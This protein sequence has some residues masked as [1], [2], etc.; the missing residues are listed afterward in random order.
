MREIATTVEAANRV[1]ERRFFTVTACV[2]G[3]AFLPS[4]TTARD[5]GRRLERETSPCLLEHLQDEIEWHPWGESAMERAR[6]KKRLV[7]ISIGRF[8]SQSSRRLESEFFESSGLADELNRRFVNVKVDYD[9]RPDIAATAFAVA[10]LSREAP[11]T[12]PP[13]P[14]VLV[15]LPDGRPV[16]GAPL[17]HETRTRLLHFAR[18]HQ[19]DAERWAT[20]SRAA[21]IASAS[22][23][24]LAPDPGQREVDATFV[25][26]IMKR[27]VNDARRPLADE[28]FRPAH[29]VLR[30]LL[31]DRLRSDNAAW[32]ITRD[33]L[34]LIER[35]GLHDQI[36]GGFHHET[37]D[38]DGR[39]PRFE[40]RLADNALLAWALSQ[41][42]RR[43]SDP[44]LSQAALGILD[45]A[46]REMLDSEDAFMAALDA[47]TDGVE[48]GFY[49][50]S[51]DEIV[52]A[53]GKTPS[54]RLFASFELGPRGVLYRQ[55]GSTDESKLL[56]VL[57]E[58]RDL[59]RRPSMD[60]RVFAGAN[61]LMIS[62]LAVSSRAFDRTADRDLA[63][64][65]AVSI[66]KRLGQPASLRRSVQG[67]TAQGSAFLTDYAALAL[68]FIDLHEATGESRWREAA[69]DFV[70]EAI[71]R[72]LDP[73]GGFFETDVAH[74][75][76]IARLKSIEDGEGL[77][78]NGAMALALHRLARFTGEGRYDDLAIRTVSAFREEIEARPAKLATL[79]A[80]AAELIETSSSS[81]P[82]VES[83]PSRT[84]RD[85]V[86][87]DVVL[88]KTQARRGEKLEARVGLALTEHWFVVGAHTK[89][90]SL[91]SLSVAVIAPEL[92]VGA[93]E[94][95]PET[96]ISPDVDEEPL[97]VH[98]GQFAIVTPLRVNNSA[99]LGERRVRIRV[100]Y[101]LCDRRECRPPESVVLE[102]PLVIMP[103]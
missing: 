43:A 21:E 101:Q 79:V 98:A 24:V 97:V 25:A 83:R 9:E 84:T 12:I 94:Y 42:H 89:S 81:T 88:T 57:R 39:L 77:S 26:S 1:R 41:S 87:I 73:N 61:G 66:L 19:D 3:L 30:V 80:A 52:E 45:W 63:R 7:L 60:T 34:R 23:D 91:A 74:E 93:P 38:E 50:W 49:L 68:G 11:V 67:E 64:R 2:V 85:P 44:L 99:S 53:L 17:T 95:P 62:A 31:G 48:G 96:T 55:D 15:L 33:L 10:R 75:P 27:V 92:V 40:K 36:G 72:F 56:S 18:D 103:K 69:Q 29:G 100:R 22:A 51:K 76:V 59:R 86:T 102:A 13:V 35:S 8:G 46:R 54:E 71:R 20:S 90:R 70:E 16:F 78:G 82:P 47:E 65:V 4:V 32:R 5:G 14:L 37:V 28:P 6:D 58:R